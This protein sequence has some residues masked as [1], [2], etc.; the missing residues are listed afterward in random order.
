M[1]VRLSMMSSLSNYLHLENT[2]ECTGIIIKPGR[3]STLEKTCS[4]NDDTIDVLANFFEVIGK[5]TF[6]LNASLSPDHYSRNSAHGCRCT[7][8]GEAVTPADRFLVTRKAF[9]LNS[10]AVPE[11]PMRE[12]TFRGQNRPA[13]PFVPAP[14]IP[15]SACGDCSCSDNGTP[16]SPP[17]RYTPKGNCSSCQCDKDG[18]SSHISYRPALR[19]DL[20]STTTGRCDHCTCSAKGLILF[21]DDQVCGHMCT[22]VHQEC[23]C[24]CPIALKCEC[25]CRL[26]ES[27]HCACSQTEPHKKVMSATWSNSE[28]SLMLTVANGQFLPAGQLETL[29]IAGRSDIKVPA[30]VEASEFNAL[31]KVASEDSWGFK[32]VAKLLNFRLHWSSTLPTHTNPRMGFIVQFTADETWATNIQSIFVPDAGHFDPAIDP[33]R[34]G[35]PV[36]SSLGIDPSFIAKGIGE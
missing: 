22:C 14:P 7:E 11:H 15:W 27:Y 36:D 9:G 25:D 31:W 32:A 10:T 33:S 17:T 24:E 20:P 2:E 12:P 4:F 3:R 29:W 28:E 26:Y 30:S 5:V 35:P 13:I 23:E 8:D 16:K 21:P 1:T 18:R 19:H 6:T 34:D